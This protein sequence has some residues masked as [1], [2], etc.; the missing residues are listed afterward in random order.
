[1]TA[2]PSQV[3][4]EAFDL[5]KVYGHG[6][7]EVVAMN[8]VS[9][10]VLRGEVVALL[11]PSGAGKSTLLTA[12]GLIN[13]PTSG[14]IEIGGTLVLDGS[15]AQLDLRAFRRKHL[16]F[17]FQ[18]ANL[19][20]FLNAVQNVQ[21]A[22]EINDVAPRQAKQRAME[23]LEYLGV[24][25]RAVNMPD[26]LSGG[27]QQRVAVARALANEPDLILADEPT[28]ALDGHRGRQ[29]MELFQNV[30]HDRGAAVIVVTHDHRAL[31]VFDTIY[32][33]EDGRLRLGPKQKVGTP[34]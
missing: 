28:A 32:E 21:L 2:N 16:G 4:I 20:P 8:D 13:P 15:R 12:M 18:K 1:M 27:Q 19:I 23:L 5:R 30:A 17:V 9:L 31:D 11:G 3:A 14:R 6:N 10:Q 33:M 29:V 25:D 22:M 26:M 7:T 34:Q 24:S